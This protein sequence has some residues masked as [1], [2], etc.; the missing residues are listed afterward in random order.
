MKQNVY[1]RTK[2][3]FVGNTGLADNFAV[4]YSIQFI[5]MM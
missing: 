4:T 3:H 1:P 2:V 5:K